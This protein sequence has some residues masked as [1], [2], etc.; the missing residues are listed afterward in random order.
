MGV[1]SDPTGGEAGIELIFCEV[2]R[3]Y[4]ETISEMFNR[5][6]ADGRIDPG[7]MVAAEITTIIKSVAEADEGITQADIA[8]ALRLMSCL[9]PGS[10]PAEMRPTHREARQLLEKLPILREELLFISLKTLRQYDEEYGTDSA[11]ELAFCFNTLILVEIGGIHDLLKN[12]NAKEITRLCRAIKNIMG[13]ESDV[14]QS[15]AATM[16]AECKEAYSLLDL[17]AESTSDEVSRK[18]R[19][20]AEVLHPDQLAGKSDGARRAAEQQMKR[21][22]EACDHILCCTNTH[23]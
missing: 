22:N 14:T 21:I 13:G 10:I 18:R 17:S 20:F 19:A 9:W 16:C 2:I 8:L 23:A 3:K 15:D 12:E 6:G 4:G 5:G 1:S 11:A 7:Q